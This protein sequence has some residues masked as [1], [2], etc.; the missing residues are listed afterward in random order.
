MQLDLRTP[1]TKWTA[2]A[3]A[4]ALC[5]CERTPPAAPERPAAAVPAPVPA[6]GV[7]GDGMP[8]DMPT[9]AQTHYQ[10][11]IY[12]VD[13]GYDKQQSSAEAVHGGDIGATAASAVTV[14]AHGNDLNGV[15]VRGK[16]GYALSK[17]TLELHGD[18]SSDFLGQGAGA[19][20]E[21]GATLTIRDSSIDTHGLVTSAVAALGGG[22]VKVYGSTLHAHG[23]TLPPDYVPHIGPG[24]KQPPAP[25]GITGTAR[26]TLT[27]GDSKSYFYDSTVIADGWGALSTDAP[28]SSYLEANDT[29]VKV[30]NS[31]YGTYADQNCKV[32]INRGS[33]DVATYAGVVAGTGQ[34]AFHDL[35]SV[36]HRNTVMVHSVMGKGPEIGVLAI[37]GGHYHSDS[38]A[39][40]VKSANGDIDIDAAELQAGNGVLIHS[41]VNDDRY[42]TKINGQPVTG[43]R[44]TLRHLSAAGDVVHADGE[45]SMQLHL[46]GVQLKGAIQNAELALDADSHWDATGNSNVLLTGPLRPEQLSAPAGVV[47]DAIAG[48]GNT[49][50]G[51]Y[52][53]RG[54]GI[55][56]V[57]AAG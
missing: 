48:S 39:I 2:L 15:L 43:V 9:T 38:D 24:M 51:R 56:Q 50:A 23:G 8:P 32:V 57:K 49:L 14:D 21:G 19:M 29:T 47:I 6:P 4:L 41:V 28:G 18:G 1:T 12:V 11:V 26:T 30:F 10:A 42:A 54:G 33:F 22:V 25:L 37:K 27:A 3:L 17:A 52:P 46:L 16:N 36:S 20:A 45:R 44:V 5:G 31:G 7:P 53:L 34:L 13:G 55:L 35:R 40:L